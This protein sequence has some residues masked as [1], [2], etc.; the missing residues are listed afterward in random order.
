MREYLVEY[1]NGELKV[2]TTVEMAIAYPFEFIEYL[3][4]KVRPKH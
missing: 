3:E 2:L 4:K 1:Q